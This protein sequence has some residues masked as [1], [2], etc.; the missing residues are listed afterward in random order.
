[1]TN[2]STPRFSED[3]RARLADITTDLDQ[4]EAFLVDYETHFQDRFD[5]EPDPVDSALS[6]KDKVKLL[7]LSAIAYTRQLAWA[8]V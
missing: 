5:P 1:M 4:W 8:I 3:V 7:A 2:T 6:T